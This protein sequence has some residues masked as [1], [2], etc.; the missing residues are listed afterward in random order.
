[1]T[2]VAALEHVHRASVTVSG[3]VTDLVF[4]CGAYV[5]QCP[6]Y[7]PGVHMYVRPCPRHNPGVHMY[8]RPCTRCMQS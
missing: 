1:M 3:L 7:S 2:D 5:C 6:Y 8:V 4:T